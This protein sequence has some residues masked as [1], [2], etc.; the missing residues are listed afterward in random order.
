MFG[1]ICND[2]IVFLKY[3]RSPERHFTH[4]MNNN[5]ISSLT[6]WP[7]HPPGKYGK[8]GFIRG[9]FFNMEKVNFE[10]KIGTIWKL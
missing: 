5:V 1:S 4:Y 6:G 10:K 7:G 8:P 3:F 2:K 9:F